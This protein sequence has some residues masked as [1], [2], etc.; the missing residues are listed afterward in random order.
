MKRYELVSQNLTHTVR[1]NIKDYFRAKTPQEFCKDVFIL[2]FLIFILA[3]LVSPPLFLKRSEYRAGTIATGDVKADRDFL[4]EEKLSTEAKKSAILKITPA[5][6]NYKSDL[7][8]TLQSQIIQIFE[9][10]SNGINRS[11]NR[12]NK[13]F[14]NA[15]NEKQVHINMALNYFEKNF[16]V[17]ITDEEFNIFYKD[18]FANTSARAICKLIDK[19]YF[20]TYITSY[21]L[22]KIDYERGIIV[23]NTKNQEES[24]ITHFHNFISIGNI[25]NDFAT[26]AEKTLS[27]HDSD[28]KWAAVSLVKKIIAPNLTLN[29]KATDDKKN[30][31]IESIKPIY[32]QVLKNE[33]IVREGERITQ[34][35]QDKLDAY[36]MIKGGKSKIADFTS[37]LGII[38]IILLMGVVL[39]SPT[40]K[41]NPKSHDLK[42]T[43]LFLALAILLQFILI[44]FGL[45][46]SDAVARAFPLLTAEDCFYAIPFVTGS[47]L[48][49]VLINDRIAIIFSVFASLMIGFLFDTRVI[50]PLFSL[51]GSFFVIYQISN[52]RQR[53]AFF[54]TGLLLGLMNGIIIFAIFLLTENTFDWTFLVNLLMGLIGGIASGILV[55]GILPLFESV[56]KFTTDIKLL[57]LGNLNQPIFQRMII[58]TPGT[59]HHSI[60]VASLVES[61]AEAIGA[62]A[63]L[64]KVS[65]YYHDIGK[66]AKPHYFIENQ[67]TGDN[68]HD[69]LSP[70]MSSL[71]IISHVKDGCE[72]AQQLKL[73]NPITNIIRQ[74]HGTSLVT[75]F[76]D[77]AKKDPD[78]TFNTLSDSDFRYPGPKP[79][80]KEAGLILLGDVI[81]AS[82]RTLTDPTPSRINNLVHERIERIFLDGQLDE[83][84]LTLRDLNKI[85]DSFI[86]I[87]T[88]IFHH[89]ISYPEQ[90]TSKNENGVK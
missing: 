4:V 84:E 65:A 59:Y 70:K 55:S 24:L 41:W 86:R 58:E 6:F 42:S 54:M 38:L 9:I 82:S 5:V 68:K 43:L 89:R 30:A 71:V 8:L 33:M 21:D 2:G 69:K 72:F 25:N 50:M 62:N 79:Q 34:S 73:G 12:K 32:F 1:Q 7:S 3:M 52:A 18:K 35:I 14:E 81:E 40:R 48:V 23:R 90:T 83:C 64:A 60:I 46:I 57:E 39:F 22:G 85:A 61:A 45:I 74:H 63:L 77:K 76:Y 28:F 27:K 16:G 53:S 36:Y 78:S 13:S 11:S 51:M 26:K 88:G 80:T 87:L 44:R 19:I 75:F 31:A 47:M 56:F 37:F 15:L 66:M 49:T 10:I 20:D 17:S 67:Q 29:V